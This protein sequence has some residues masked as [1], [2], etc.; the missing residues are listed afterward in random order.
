MSPLLVLHVLGVY[1]ILGVVLWIAINLQRLVKQSHGDVHIK[2]H[3]NHREENCALWEWRDARWVL[4][5]QTLSAEV[6]PGPPPPYPGAENGERAKTWIRP[7][8]L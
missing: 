5:S 4:I 6:D 8:R 1:A 3:G 2:H 7:Q